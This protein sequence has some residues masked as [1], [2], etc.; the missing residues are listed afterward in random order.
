[1]RNRSDESAPA[2]FAAFTGGRQAGADDVEMC[3]LM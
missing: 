1:M 2:R 3:I